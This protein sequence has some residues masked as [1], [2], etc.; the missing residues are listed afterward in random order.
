MGP[1]S[2]HLCIIKEE[3]FN[4]KKS[5]TEDTDEK[6]SN[7]TNTGKAGKGA[8]LSWGL[9]PTGELISLRE[10]QHLDGLEMQT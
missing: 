9:A 7:N 10:L 1:G 6:G 3:I 4:L 2:Q 8:R 5:V